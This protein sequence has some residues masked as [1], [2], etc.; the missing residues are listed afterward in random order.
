MRAATVPEPVLA[1]WQPLRAGLVDL[2]YYDAEG[3][4]VPRRPAAAA[5]QQRHRQVQG[6]RPDAAFPAGPATSAAPGGAGRDPRKRME[7]NLLLGGDHPYPERLGYTWLEF[8]A[9]STKHASRS[10]ARW[11]AGEGGVRQGH[12]AAL[13][14]SSV[15]T[16]SAATLR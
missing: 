10:S 13:V 3:V 16:G 4:L 8:R 9:G 12:R 5:R 2:F 15:P 14:L 11:A 7:W 1:R 6:P